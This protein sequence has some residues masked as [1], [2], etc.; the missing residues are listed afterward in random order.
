MRLAEKINGSR[1]TEKEYR[2]LK[3]EL[4]YSSIKDFAEDLGLFYRK[5]ILREIVKQK[6]TAATIN[7]SLVHHILS[8]KEFEE[9]FHLF[10]SIKPTGMWG[11]LCDN[12]IERSLK[13]MNEFYEQQDSFVTV[14]GDALQK[15]QYN[16][17]GELVSF[18]E[19]GGK[20]KESAAKSLQSVMS[21]FKGS[22][23][24]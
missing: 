22:N 20:G 19:R 1:K 6:E 13:S 8:G 5:Y 9:K 2:N 3:E 11:E 23:S 10:N 14:F 4:S 18:K 24:E 12:L 21:E 7:G 16:H 17:K 15:T